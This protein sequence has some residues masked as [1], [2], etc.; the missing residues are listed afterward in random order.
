MDT[1]AE[2]CVIRH[3]QENA[4]NAYDRATIFFRPSNASF[5]SSDGSHTSIGAMLVRIQTP[6]RSF[7]VVD[8][9]VVKADV[10]VLIGLDLL[11]NYSLV[12]NSVKTELQSKL[13]GWSMPL[14][15]KLGHN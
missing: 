2:Q 7:I 6:D 9:D 3:R 1:G 11:D 5:S 15:R 14:T 13:Q 8:F 10:P 4:H 12:R